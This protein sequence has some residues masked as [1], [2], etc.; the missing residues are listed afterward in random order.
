MHL[1]WE[2]M[3]EVGVL[4]STLLKGQGLLTDIFVSILLVSLALT[5]SLGYRRATAVVHWTP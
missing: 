4:Q 5:S 1:R 2:S 3:N